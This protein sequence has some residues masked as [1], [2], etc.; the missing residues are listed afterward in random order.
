AAEFV[1]PRRASDT[2]RRDN[3]SR[4]PEGRMHLLPSLALALCFVAPPP[5]PSTTPGLKHTLKGHTGTVRGAMFSPDG[6]TLVSA[7]DDGQLNIWDVSSGKA[8]V[9]TKVK[10][11]FASVEYS[12]DGKLLLTGGTD[13]VIRLWDGRTAKE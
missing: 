4:S 3:C 11:G 6:K 2:I 8:V 13:R 12:R 7:G 1:T 9:S 10:G 5:Q